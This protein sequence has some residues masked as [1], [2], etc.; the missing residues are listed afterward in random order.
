[1]AFHIEKQSIID[2]DVTVYYCGSNHW[3]DNREA[4]MVWTSDSTPTNM[5]KN[6]DGTNGGWNGA[7]I[8]EE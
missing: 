3:S 6:T 8:V 1:M 2:P 5:M 4:R 7:S